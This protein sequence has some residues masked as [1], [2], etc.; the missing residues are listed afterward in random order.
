MGKPAARVSDMTVHGG[1]VMPPGCPTVLIGGLPAARL[2]DMHV[3]PMLTP[4]LPPIPHVGGPIIMGSSGVM[5]GGMPAARVM[6]QA[7][8]VGPPDMIA[9]GCFTVLIGETSP[10]GGGGGG[11]GASNAGAAAAAAGGSSE[12]ESGE[13]HWVEFL[14]ADSAG[15]PLASVPFELQDPSGETARGA[16]AA[17]GKIRRDGLS[18]AGDCRVKV[19]ALS[20]AAWSVEEAQVGDSLTLTAEAWGFADGTAARLIIFERQVRGAAR[21]I[22]TIAAEVQGG[23]VEAEWQYAYPPRSSEEEASFQGYWRPEYYFVV[24]IGAVQTVSGLLELTDR[25]EIEVRDEEGQPLAGEDY[26]L[27]LADGSVREG[28]LD[29]AGCAREEDV[30]PRPALLQLPEL[31]APPEP[32][33]ESSP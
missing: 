20:E 6:D 18:A 19:F 16:S 1:T 26:R 25:L 10:G 31:Q 3:C 24:Q 22:A 2:T 14:L 13:R 7:I 21:A 29:D 11:A 5:I 17:D 33:A 30:P 32:G 9:M 23:R 27:Y 15:R 12:A 28:Q 8:C 4:G